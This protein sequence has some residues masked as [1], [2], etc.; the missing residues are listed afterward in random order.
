MS[1]K[2]RKQKQMERELRRNKQFQYN[3]EKKSGGLWS[4]P[5]PEEYTF[6]AR[7]YKKLFHYTS[8]DN[9]YSI[10]KYGIILGGINVNDQEKFNAPCL[11]T[12]NEFHN[13]SLRPEKELGQMGDG[14]YRLTI[15]CP[16]D[17]DKL[18]NHGW[19]D[20]TYSNNLIRGV[21]SKNNGTGNV[22]N[23]YFYLGDIN[24]SMIKEIKVWNSKTHYWDRPRKKE[25]EDLCLEYENKP[26]KHD[27]QYLPSQLRICGF[28]FN[29]YTGMVKK[30]HL[31]ND[32]KDV[33]KDL[34]VLSDTLCEVFK[35]SS[36]KNQYRDFIPKYKNNVLWLFG[37]RSS[38]GSIDKLIYVVVETYNMLVGKSQKINIYEYCEKMRMTLDNFSK[39]VSC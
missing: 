15:K 37:N 14:Y 11:T 34:Y 39:Y 5:Q 12:E 32:H 8:G 19:F 20:K 3:Q 2:N 31:E 9:L 35:S 16:T 10:L 24:P 36:I 6:D 22:D 18:I 26:Y 17:A 33:W 21:N 7:G 28:Q 30:F 27:F 1:K 38:D 13:P 29:D 25:K 4:I 23:Q